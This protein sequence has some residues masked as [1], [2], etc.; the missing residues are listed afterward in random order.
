MAPVERMALD[1]CAQLT[2]EGGRLLVLDGAGCLNPSRLC[3]AAAPLARNVEVVSIHADPDPIEGFK[4]G[5]EAACSREP[6]Q[7]VLLTGL[8]EPLCQSQALTRETAREVGRIKQLL[9]ELAAMGLEVTVLCQAA[10]GLGTRSY[11]LASLCAAAQEVHNPEW[12]VRAGRER[13][14]AA[15]A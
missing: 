14:S 8:L 1:V 6:V 5:L 4:L 10:N 3:R 9:E 11:V 15:I 7:R 2:W 13:D 12:P